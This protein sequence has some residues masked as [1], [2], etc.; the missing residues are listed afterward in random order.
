M[1]KLICLC[2]LACLIL[3]SCVTA[4]NAGGDPI[5]GGAESEN[6]DGENIPEQSPDIPEP[7]PETDPE[8]DTAELAA[9]IVASMDLEEKIGQM[10][11]PSARSW[12][13]ENG[14]RRSV[15]E[16]NATLA[17]AI[18]ELGL[19][20]VILF[21][22]STAGTAAT[23]G[24]IYDMQEAATADGGLPLLV[25]VD[26]E[27]GYIVRLG[28]GTG[29]CGNMALGATG[30]P[31][32]AYTAASVMGGELAAL[33]FNVDFAPVLDVNSNPSN[34][35]I[36]V[37][38]FS[39]DPAAAARFGE[40]FIE[41]LHSAGV[42]AA[43]K[44]FPGHG[45]TAVDSHSGLPCID[46]TLDELMDSELVPFRAGVE[47][48][49]DIVMTAHIQ[50]PGIEKTTY[51]SVSTGEE[52]T[53]PATLSKTVITDIL[54]TELGFD[55]VVCTD[56][57]N[58]AAIS[59][60]FAPADAA[61][62]AINAGVDILLM[63]VD[64][65]SEAGIENCREYI[66]TIAGMVESGAIAKKLIDA[67]AA[68]IVR[69]KLERGI[70]ADGK[71]R[72]NR[73]TVI[74]GALAAVGSYEN[75]ETERLIAEKAVTIVK[76]DGVLPARLA[77]GGSAVIFCSYPNEVTAAEYEISLLRK[78]GVIPDGADV[79]VICY[80]NRSAYEFSDII[81]SADA[82][83]VSVES[84]GTADIT[85]GWQAN[86]VDSLI[87]VSHSCGKKITVISI[88]LPYDLARYQEADALMAVYNAVGMDTAPT[89]YD[90]ECE[91]YGPNIPAA[92]SALFGGSEV[93]GTLPVSIPALDANHRYTESIL[94]PRGF[95]LTY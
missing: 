63:P 75:H 4:G 86:F 78:N 58:M 67:A 1:K 7:V 59:A 74:D 43:L 81:A 65:S 8:P 90:G 46:K 38:S 18:R 68:R 14:E 12:T 77:E 47:A 45:D 95:G 22:E 5:N 71:E 72:K 35:I 11:M 28:T 50:Y 25:S 23:A 66:R 24:L 19:G 13:D 48:G 62:Y 56:A 26:Q 76:N 44:H 6:T 54:R 30:D 61:Y 57:M 79:S 29:F 20:G 87:S 36:G 21:A 64:L 31:E 16:L 69:L 92:V 73:S 15:T 32:N 39:D 85:G 2:L 89:A 17:A 49:A 37:R 34:P 84:Y 93:S 88:Q 51:P 60:H 3:T 42:S 83:A 40:K 41:G 10:I 70:I 80:Q 91:I 82:V 27:G 55:G 94:Y 52:I 53:L 9:Q 33:G